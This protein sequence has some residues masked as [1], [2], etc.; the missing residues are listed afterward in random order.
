MSGFRLFPL[1]STNMNDEKKIFL[2][3]QSVVVGYA[4]S[5]QPQACSLQALWY[6]PVKILPII[7][8]IKKTTRL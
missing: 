8:L 6:L 7:Y 1:K 3:L 2:V 4:S 5:L